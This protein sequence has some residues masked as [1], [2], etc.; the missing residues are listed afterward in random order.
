MSKKR[1]EEVP[2]VVDEA[3][4]PLHR[5][6]KEIS[7]WV[8][9][10]QRK[11][12]CWVAGLW[13][14]RGT[15]KTSLLLT[16]LKELRRAE[17]QA[18]LVLPN[19]E[20]GQPL[21]Q[22]FAPALARED[23]DLLYLLLHHLDRR[24]RKFDDNA[25]KRALETIRLLETR[26][27]DADRFLGYEAEVAQSNAEIPSAFARVR[28]A[29][30]NST[31]AIR[32]AF[33]ELLSTCRAA[34]TRD[35]IFVLCIDDLDLQPHRTLEMLEIVE[36]FLSHH[37]G[38]VVLIAAD[39]NLFLNGLTQALLKRRAIEH[40]GLAGA[41][42]AKLVPYGWTLPLPSPTE[43]FEE[44]WGKSREAEL[45]GWWVRD[46]EAADIAKEEARTALAG[47]LPR[48]YRMLNAAD[49]RLAALREEL[50]AAEGSFTALSDAM[51]PRFGEFDLPADLA[52]FV[53]G[54]ALA[55]V[56]LPELG[57]LDFLTQFPRK[58]LDELNLYRHPDAADGLTKGAGE[59]QNPRPPGRGVFSVTL[60]SLHLRGTST[61]E[62]QALLQG[63]LSL[64]DALD[65][66]K[67]RAERFWTISM[68]GDAVTLSES[69]WRG[70]F[71][72]DAV[73]Q[74]HLD[75]REAASESKSVAENMRRARDRAFRFLENRDLRVLQSGVELFALAKL[76]FMIWLGWQMRYASNVT[77]VNFD[78]SSRTFQRFEQ[79]ERLTYGNRGQ[80]LRLQLDPSLLPAVDSDSSGGDAILIVD[81]LGKSNSQQTAA[82]F[83]TPGETPVRTPDAYR[84][85]VPPGGTL[86]PGELERLLQDTLE[87]IGQLRERRRVKRLHLGFAGPAAVG[88]FLG[89]QLNAQGIEILLYDFVSE[90]GGQYRFVFPLERNVP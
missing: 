5:L 72:R 88:F 10:D 26:R 30:A 8:S 60:D 77:A 55:D 45:P 19:E 53:S 56:Q 36:L 37:S 82:F 85:F 12:G 71:T 38:V 46:P 24:Y 54:V 31:D 33:G 48:S 43:R 80:L 83:E 67:R 74:W 59:Q 69:Y 50:G 79:Q 39:R 27:R 84:L 17:K 4:A 29:I 2:R 66:K 75:V 90:N 64:Y 11:K 15:G 65:D 3:G 58:F 47:V 62:A 28:T 57:L 13:G 22:L 14:G 70:R 1:R 63:L 41:L 87:T 42:T 34:T 20:S 76:P 68:T 78:Q 40:G 7:A 35:E 73:A 51:Q 49:N 21:S 52:P 9:D 6:A 44:L 32:T 61:L 89:K 25:A 86:H 81:V 23:D 18:R 16:V